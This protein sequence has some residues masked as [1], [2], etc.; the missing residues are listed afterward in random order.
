MKIQTNQA[1]YSFIGDPH[2]GRKFN[3]VFFHRKGE[4]EKAQLEEFKHQLN[5]ESDVCIMVGD[6]FDTYIVDNEVLMSVYL[7]LATVAMGNPNKEYLMM[8]GNH[9]ISRTADVT[10][11]FCILSIMCSNLPNIK[12]FTKTTKYK[13][14]IGTEILICP[15][16]EFTTTKDEV[17]KF[18]DGNKVDLAVGHWDTE[19]I[20][21]EHN[22][23]PLDVLVD[24]TDTVVTGHVHTA[25][26]KQI[27]NLK[28]YR[29]GSMLPYAHSEDPQEKIY[30]TRTIEQAQ[31]EL[32]SN[33]N[34]YHN[35]CLRL[36]VIE[37]EELPTEID[38][39]QLTVKKVQ[40]KNPDDK[41]EVSMGVFDFKQLFY[42]SFKENEVPEDITDSY[43]EEYN[44]RASHD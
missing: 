38:C 40:G 10:T 43:W 34:V 22:L 36:V 15:Y 24:M 28:F 3:N 8:L 13:T 19:A 33:P 39:L 29:T 44:K 23:V 6:L 18:K 17:A 26:M 32:A 41:L 11:S 37:G 2:F 9:D 31:E 20:A 16:S 27:G 7:T 25:E 30:V 21:G 1:V 5:E 42:D 14:N 12:F 35:K 4:R